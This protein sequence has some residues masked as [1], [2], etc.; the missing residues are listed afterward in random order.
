MIRQHS[1]KN[2]WDQTRLIFI[3]WM[4]I[5]VAFS[6]QGILGHNRYNNYRI[7]EYQFPH[8]VHH[9]SLYIAYPSEYG[10][11][12]HSGPLF[13]FF[14]APFYALPDW[15]GLLC[16][17]L[18]NVLLL[19][20]TIQKL[21]FDQRHRNMICWLALPDI[22]A[23]TLSE[24][25]N[26]LLAVF[27]I[28][29][30]LMVK[31]DQLFWAAFFIMVG[32]VMKL[33]G[34]VAL[35]FFFFTPRRF[36]LAGYL[37][38]WGIVL[39]AL[40]MIVSSPHYII[41]TYK[42]W[43]AA[44]DEKNALNVSLTTTQDVSVMGLA[45][46]VLRDPTLPSLPFLIGGVLLFAT[47][48]LRINKFRDPQFQLLVLAATLMSPVLFST[49]SEDVTYIIAVVGAGI[50][51]I[52]AK[53]GIWKY[54]L[55]GALIFVSIIPLWTILPLGF[56]QQYPFIYVYKV[57]P[58]LLIW[59]TIICKLHTERSREPGVGSQENYFTN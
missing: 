50:Y 46:R 26:P 31:K 45:R 41:D 5:A 15:L 12:F 44:L 19:F 23:S 24:Q 27:I 36:T 53:N 18:L 43:F 51:F 6:I 48:Y 52:L 13:A 17:N 56:R 21:P 20:W 32:A 55:L 22:V 3:I 59:L 49:G 28:M 25:F 11:T 40:P 30:Y 57:I 35:A 9:V 29:A 42:E 1:T 16:W 33:Y 8:L 7:F 54:Y 14:M 47:V 34:I 39:F 10:D 38:L 2:L 4:L 58:Y 37:V